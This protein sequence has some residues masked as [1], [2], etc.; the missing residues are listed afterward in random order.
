MFFT[1]PNKVKLF[2][3]KFLPGIGVHKERIITELIAAFLLCDD[4]RTFE[5][6]SKVFI[7]SAKNKTSVRNFFETENF[8]STHYLEL[9]IASLIIED[10]KING[11]DNVYVLLFDGTC[12]QRGGFTLIPNAIKYKDKKINKKGKPSTKA[13]TFTQGLLIRPD[14]MRIPMPRYSY[15]TRKYCKETKQ[16]YYTQHEQACML[17]KKCRQF[18][19]TTAEFVVVADGFF[20]SK[21]IFET[22]RAENAIYITS[23]DKGRTYEPKKKLYNKGLKKKKKSKKLT[24]TKGSEKYTSKHIRYSSGSGKQKRDVYTSYSEI[25]DVSKIGTVRVVYSWKQI[26]KKGKKISESY[27]VLLCSDKNMNYRKIIELY[28][29]RW[30]IE[31]FFRELKSEIGLCDYTGKSFIALERYIDVCLM[32]YAFLEWDRIKRIK[33]TRSKKEK[34]KIQVCRTRG[35]ISLLKKDCFIE[36]KETLLNAK[37]NIQSLKKAG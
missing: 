7:E 25:L 32:A 26:P 35:L 33:L 27:K 16:K 3:E 31:I 15:Y 10:I 2:T 11:I 37:N 8:K 19:P 22:C 17:I 18:V 4:K 9:I 6:L 14:G 5:S 34:G 21:I 23:A 36:N 13:H 24:I 12:I 30:Q 1:L 28:A 29:L 20:D